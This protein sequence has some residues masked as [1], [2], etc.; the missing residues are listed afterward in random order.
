MNYLKQTAVTISSLGLILANNIVSAGIQVYPFT[1]PGNYTESNQSLTDIHYGLGRLA[2][3]HSPNDIP[4]DI[5]GSSDAVI[6]D[7][8]NDGN[9]DIYSS[10]RL[11]NCDKLYLGDG[12]GNFTVNN[13]SSPAYQGHFKISA[14]DFDNDGNLD[15][16]ISTQSSV[17]PNILF[18]GDGLG[19]FTANNIPGDISHSY[20]STV[21]DFDSDGN[22]DLYVTNST[23]STSSGQNSLYLGVGGGTFSNAN[24]PG[25]IGVSRNSVAADFNSD[26]NLDLYVDNYN[27]T[28]SY[29]KIYFGDGTGAFPSNINHSIAY[30]SFGVSSGDFN[31]DNNADLYITRTGGANDLYLGNGAGGFVLNNA[32][33]TSMAQSFD[34]SANDFN[35]DGNLDLYVANTGQNKMYL[36]DGNGSFVSN[37]IIGDLDISWGVHTGDVNNDGIADIYISN[38]QNGVQNRLFLSGYSTLAPSIQANI[39]FNF[40][41]P[42]TDFIE[43]LS[44][45]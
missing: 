24:I 33:F 22:D 41:S 13:I 35:D 7:F 36:G 26:G 20:G 37:D 1:N 17:W 4:G 8:N 2:V 25:D 31:N 6:G 10:C 30:Q 15:I 27:A 23:I 44:P 14:A 42:L 29:R 21:G 9:L 5:H 39:P 19:S 38:Y 16:Y 12:T 28:N 3:V 40:N 43:V 11:Y 18:L 32:S 34:V 45:E